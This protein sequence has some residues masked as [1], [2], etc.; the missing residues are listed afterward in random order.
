MGNKIIFFKLDPLLEKALFQVAG[1]VSEHNFEI[2]TIQKFENK[3]IADLLKNEYFRGV[4]LECSTINDVFF[5][6]I[7]IINQLSPKTKIYVFSNKIT[8]GLVSLLE[9]RKIEKIMLLPLS[10][11]IINKVIFELKHTQNLTVEPIT[12]KLRK[13]ILNSTYSEVYSELFIICTNYIE[14]ISRANLSAQLSMLRKVVLSNDSYSEKLKND[15]E[16]NFTLNFSDH[17][18][19][20]YVVE[21]FIFDLVDLFYQEQLI[22]KKPFFLNVFECINTQIHSDLFLSNVAEQA[23]ISASY[24]SRAISKEFGFSFNKYIQIKKIEEA[25]KEFY[26]N[27]EKVIDVSF[28]LSFSEPSY[29][30]K[31]FKKIQGETPIQYKKNII[32]EKEKAGN[33]D[34]ESCS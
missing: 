7:N 31:V 28:K 13:L 32:L 34:E 3:S 23:N 29:F 5:R 4:F 24:L 9:K 2:C 11:R 25:K 6:K 17:E 21:F 12:L 27:D 20:A 26:F 14:Q 16:S 18:L 33:K 19:T 8:T 22:R 10:F 1:N 30:S 15:F